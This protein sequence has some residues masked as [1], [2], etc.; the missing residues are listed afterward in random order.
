MSI[1]PPLLN[2]GLRSQGLVSGRAYILYIQALVLYLIYLPLGF[3][4]SLEIYKPKKKRKKG[5]KEKE[6]PKKKGT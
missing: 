1:E 3:W 2:L 4:I 5:E 6:P